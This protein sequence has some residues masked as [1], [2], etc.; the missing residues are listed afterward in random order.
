MAILLTIL[1]VIY[2]LVQ[3]F[4][5]SFL[6]QPAVLF[7]LYGTA[8]LFR[9]KKPAAPLK[10]NFQFG[11]IVTSHQDTTFLKPIVDSLQKQTYGKFN[12]Y[13]V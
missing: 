12:A 6:I 8:K 10:K 1:W 3:A 2:L 11:I 5:A 4:L 7:L 9:A 13:L